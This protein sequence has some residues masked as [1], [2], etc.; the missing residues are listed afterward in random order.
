MQTKST[1]VC[2]C[3]NMTNTI[4]YAY[5]TKTTMHNVWEREI[6]TLYWLGVGQLQGKRKREKVKVC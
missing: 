1:Q 2:D 4:W 5:K 3:M 6:D